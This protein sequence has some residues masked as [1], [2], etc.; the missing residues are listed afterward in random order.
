G[1]DQAA[2]G[3]DGP[4][5]R[6]VQIAADQRAPR[7]RPA[8]TQRRAHAAR[9]RATA[10]LRSAAELRAREASFASAQC[11]RCFLLPLFLPDFLSLASLGASLGSAFDCA[12]VS[13][14]SDG[15]PAVISH[16]NVPL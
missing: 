3:R 16:V 12:A 2:A 5:A 15:S 7:R 13:S 1:P 11:L 14:A 6:Q 8:R 9:T 4:R 10:R